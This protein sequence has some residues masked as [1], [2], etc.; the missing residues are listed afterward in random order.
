M[1]DTKDSGTHPEPPK[2]SIADK[3]K[4]A[5]AVEKVDEK[6]DEKV[7]G[8]NFTPRERAEC[9]KK[10]Q[11]ALASH[12]NMESNIPPHHDYWSLLGQFRAMQ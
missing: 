3:V 4:A 9:L 10:I 7:E 5:A 6:L 1:S 11:D 2:P 8:K 12:G